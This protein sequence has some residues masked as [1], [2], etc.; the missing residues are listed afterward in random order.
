MM[1][2]HNENH[3]TPKVSVST[4]KISWSQRGLPPGDEPMMVDRDWWWVDD[5][6]KLSQAVK[7]MG[8]RT[9]VR[10]RVSPALQ[11]KSILVMMIQ[12]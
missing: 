4:M 8:W 7:E 12:G 9:Q 1:V 6:E 2:G 10:K 5:A 11:T 3:S